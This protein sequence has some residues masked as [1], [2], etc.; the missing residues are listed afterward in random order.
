MWIGWCLGSNT[1]L[2][3]KREVE[4]GVLLRTEIPVGAGAPQ[5]DNHRET[6]IK[7]ETSATIFLD[8][9]YLLLQTKLSK[10]FKNQNLFLSLFYGCNQQFTGLDEDAI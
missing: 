8:I 4:I 3:R 9:G 10:R 2:C 5:A 1:G 6:T 7:R